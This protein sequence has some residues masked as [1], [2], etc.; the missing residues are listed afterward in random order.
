MFAAALLLSTVAGLSTG[1]GGVIVVCMSDSGRA[2]SGKKLGM[3]EGIVAGFMLTI[4]LVDLL[5]EALAT[6]VLSAASC[7]VYFL[8]GA[9]AFAL[10][11]RV[12]PEPEVVDLFESRVGKCAGTAERRQL[13][14]TGIL[15]AISIAIHNFPEGVSPVLWAP[16]VGCEVQWRLLLLNP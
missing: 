2:Q 7:F 3:W 6:N 15:T 5:P 9:A 12:L 10:L 1:L 11:K 13:L 14:F 8:L 16:C 4:S